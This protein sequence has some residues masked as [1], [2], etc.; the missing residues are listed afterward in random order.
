MG[1]RRG[2]IYTLIWV[3]PSPF[4]FG[5]V[6]TVASCRASAGFRHLPRS[7]GGSIV[8]PKTHFWCSLHPLQRGQQRRGFTD[9]RGHVTYS[10]G[11]LARLKVARCV[12]ACVFHVLRRCYGF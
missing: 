8:V 3:R 7:A 5:L 11:T 6:P 2:C 1:E 4:R 10:T 9:F 12:L